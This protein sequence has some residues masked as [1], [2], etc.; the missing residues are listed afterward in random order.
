MPLSQDPEKRA[1]QLANLKPAA[2]VTHGARSG[3][4]IQQATAEHLAS[5]AKQFPNATTAELTLQASRWAQIERL[6][7]YVHARGL[8]RNQRSGT[9]VAAAEFLAR[10]SLAFERQQERLALRHRPGWQWW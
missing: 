7:D 2:A 5:L 6:T 10:L 3:Q 9:V 8:I 1:H 4:L